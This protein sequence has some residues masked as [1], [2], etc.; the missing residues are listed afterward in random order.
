MRRVLKRNGVGMVKTGNRSSKLLGL[1]AKIFEE[2]SELESKCSSCRSIVKKS[3]AMLVA[4]LLTSRLYLPSS[5]GRSSM[6]MMR[7]TF[8]PYLRK[9]VSPHKISLLEIVLCKAYQ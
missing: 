8:D 5:F 7:L 9:R 6:S 3:F 1:T 4:P 2:G